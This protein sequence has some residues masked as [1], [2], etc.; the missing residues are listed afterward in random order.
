MILPISRVLDAY[1]GS[2]PSWV[3]AD[4]LVV[5]GRV[6]VLAAMRCRR[7]ESRVLAPDPFRANIIPRI[8]GE[9]GLD[10]A[11]RA[12]LEAALSPNVEATVVAASEM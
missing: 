2:R 8:L 9:K 7:N 4:T 12:V 6:K 1:H 5:V 10:D 11:A 3:E